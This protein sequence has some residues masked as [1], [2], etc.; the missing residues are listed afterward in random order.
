VTGVTASLSASA[1]AAAERA[2]ELGRG[3]GAWCSFDTNLRP[4][5]WRD[6]PRAPL[7]ALVSH[8]DVCFAGLAHA[9]L[10]TGATG[11]EAAAAQLARLGPATVVIT[12]GSHGALVCEGDRLLRAEPVPVAAVDPVGAGDAFAAGFPGGRLLG[13]PIEECLALAARHGAEAT[14]SRRDAAPRHGPAA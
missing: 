5:P 2:L 11:G 14:T 7:P 13:R 4:R 6:D 10:L 3:A 9:E 1:A 8:A 12:L